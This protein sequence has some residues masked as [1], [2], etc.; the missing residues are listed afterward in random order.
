MP[1]EKSIV[2]VGL[3]LVFPS[4]Y[5]HWH[6]DDVVVEVLPDFMHVLVLLFDA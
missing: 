3:Y 2:D 1:E 4:F 6:V 5:K